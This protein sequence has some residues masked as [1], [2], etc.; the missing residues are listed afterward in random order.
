M[1]LLV[2]FQVINVYSFIGTFV[3]H[4]RVFLGVM[5]D[6]V[7][8]QLLLGNEVYPTCI[9]HIAFLARQEC[10]SGIL[11]CLELKGKAN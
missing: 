5:S 4:K 3:A 10:F 9:T 7:I 11:C 6:G 1:A 8:S 2:F